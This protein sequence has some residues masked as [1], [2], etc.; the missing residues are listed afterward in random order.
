MTLRS[1]TSLPWP[2]T[3]ILDLCFLAYL[4]NEFFLC[5]SPCKIEDRLRSFSP[6]WEK[7]WAGMLGGWNKRAEMDWEDMLNVADKPKQTGDETLYYDSDVATHF[8]TVAIR[9]SRP[10]AHVESRI[11]REIHLS[12]NVSQPKFVQ[13]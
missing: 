6:S 11:L 3:L 5:E 7:R 8:I 9:P 13:S 12:P 1:T 10:Y 4:N 2:Y